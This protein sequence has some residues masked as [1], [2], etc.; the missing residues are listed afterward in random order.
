[1]GPYNGYQFGQQNALDPYMEVT[2]PDDLFVVPVSGTQ[3]LLGREPVVDNAQLLPQIIDEGGKIKFLGNGY[4]A[5]KDLRTLLVYASF[6]C[7]W[8][9]KND[10]SYDYCMSETSFKFS[11][12]AMGINYYGKPLLLTKWTPLMGSGVETDM[13]RV[14]WEGK[15]K[16]Q[17]SFDASKSKCHMPVFYYWPNHISQDKPTYTLFIGVSLTGAGLLPISQIQPPGE[18]YPVDI[19]HASYE[20][21]VD[22]SALSQ[23]PRDKGGNDTP[24]FKGVGKWTDNLLQFSSGSVTYIVGEVQFGTWTFKPLQGYKNPG[25]LDGMSI[26]YSELFDSP[27][28]T[29]FD[30]IR[31]PIRQS[32]A[33]LFRIRIE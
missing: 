4:A 7:A 3:P 33:Y 21:V 32:E 23:K 5:I 15:H 13:D 18:K 28:F 30:K 16:V 10:G 20:D 27:L 19:P 17:A 8:H 2:F 12:R 29:I 14:L 6:P 9:S 24:N 11:R 22:T 25:S 1:M 26:P 31:L